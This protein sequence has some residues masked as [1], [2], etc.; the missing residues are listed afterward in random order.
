MSIELTKNVATKTLEYTLWPL[1]YAYQAMGSFGGTSHSDLN[2][3]SRAFLV[4]ASE[5]PLVTVEYVPKRA[6]PDQDRED[7]PPK[8]E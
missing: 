4:E 3:E 1:K 5:V 7:S 8:V 6:F 2:D